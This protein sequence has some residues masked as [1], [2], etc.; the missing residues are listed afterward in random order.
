MSVAGRLQHHR[1]HRVGHTLNDDRHL[2]AAADD[3]ADGIVDREA[4]GDIAAGSVDVERDGPGV[5]VRKL[6]QAL[7][8]VASDVLFDVADEVDIAQAIRR[9]F[10]ESAFYRVDEIEDETV[11]EIPRRRHL[12]KLRTL[13][14]GLWTSW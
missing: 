10:S 9:F 12:G 13:P 1:S 2:D 8:D 7:D 4:V 14:F 5:V 3:L 11:V 6:A